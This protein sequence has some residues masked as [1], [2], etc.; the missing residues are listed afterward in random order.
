[1]NFGRDFLAVDDW[2]QGGWV[3]TKG[4]KSDQNELDRSDYKALVLLKLS[5]IT[6]CRVKSEKS[7]KISAQISDFP[8][9]S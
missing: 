8:K 3:V 6:K 7:G 5:E 2:I 4:A 9:I 1:M